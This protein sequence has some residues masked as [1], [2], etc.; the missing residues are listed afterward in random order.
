M[1]NL[2]IQYVLLPLKYSLGQRKAGAQAPA[3]F[4][5]IQPYPGGLSLASANDEFHST[6]TGAPVLRRI[7]GNR[8]GFATA[9]GAKLSFR[10]AFGNQVINSSLGATL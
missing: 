2:N 9:D 1:R 8:L 10:N 5:A 3:S 6:V 4:Q 7:A